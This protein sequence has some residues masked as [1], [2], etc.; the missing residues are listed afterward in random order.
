[1][2]GQSHLELATM[3]E[4]AQNNFTGRPNQAKHILA[5][6]P[7][8][9]GLLTQMDFLQREIPYAISLN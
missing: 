1:M 9:V 5:G 6:R 8:A 7:N 2:A 3:D 4:K